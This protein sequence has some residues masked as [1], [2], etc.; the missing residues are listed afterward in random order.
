MKGPVRGVVD[1]SGLAFIQNSSKVVET[2]P[3]PCPESVC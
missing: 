2:L 1:H 3:T